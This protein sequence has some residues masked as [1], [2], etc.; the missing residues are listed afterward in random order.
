MEQGPEPS[1]SAVAARAHL[2]RGFRLEQ[3]GTYERALDAYRDALAASPAPAEQVDA[4]LRMARVYR[5]MADYAL[6][7]SEAREAVRLAEAIDA[8]DLAAE[9][10]NVEVGALQMQSDFDAADALAQRALA[11]AESPRVRGITLQNL[12]RGAAERRDFTTSDPY[13]DESIEAF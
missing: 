12:G 6:C 9:A 4:R 7:V 5:A 10:M 8:H 3:A 1:R 2:D 13:F 11:I